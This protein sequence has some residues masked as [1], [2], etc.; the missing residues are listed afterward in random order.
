M[1]VRVHA[2]S[3]NFRDI[4]IL[5]GR[6][7]LPDRKGLVPT[8]DGAGEVVEVGAGVDG[9]KAGSAIGWL[10]AFRRFQKRN[11]LQ[12]LGAFRRMPA[13][14]GENVEWIPIQPAQL[15]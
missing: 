2:V 1:L 5:R 15:G 8:S 3:L 14:P 11:S 6:Y 12:V 10:D 13:A 4:A 9:F 7:S